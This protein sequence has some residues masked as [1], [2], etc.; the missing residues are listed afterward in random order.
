M[1][2]IIAPPHSAKGNSFTVNMI[3]PHKGVVPPQIIFVPFALFIVQ[4]QAQAYLR[5][6]I[7]ENL[8]YARCH[9]VLLQF[10]LA[11][12]LLAAALLSM[13]SV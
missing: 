8:A 4:T 5:N 10:L 13:W 6:S 3:F 7:T 11:C 9:F 12:C 1:Q 2:N